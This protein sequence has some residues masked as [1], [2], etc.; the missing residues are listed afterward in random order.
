M[1]PWYTYLMEWFY[2]SSKME[3][4]YFLKFIFILKSLLNI[5]YLLKYFHW[6]T[7]KTWT[8]KKLDPEKRGPRKTWTL[9][10]WTL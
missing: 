7:S 10:T 8:L 2:K 5:I 9:K 1:L 3:N 6:A 4:M